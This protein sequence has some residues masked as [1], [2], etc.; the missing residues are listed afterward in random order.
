LTFGLNNPD[1]NTLGALAMLNSC[2]YAAPDT[3]FRVDRGAK[4]SKS[5]DRGCG[6]LG[7]LCP[8]HGQTGIHVP[9]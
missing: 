8:D 3:E 7:V 2:I 9:D 4:L 6:R 5:E 1:V